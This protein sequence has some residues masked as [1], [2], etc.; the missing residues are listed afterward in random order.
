MDSLILSFDE[1]HSTKVMLRAWVF[2]CPCFKRICHPS[3]KPVSPFK[4]S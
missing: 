3:R 2:R 1:F 4:L